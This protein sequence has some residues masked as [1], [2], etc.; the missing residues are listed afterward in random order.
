MA[1]TVFEP[2]I[3]IL[4]RLTALLKVFIV[5]EQYTPELE[6]DRRVPLHRGRLAGDVTLRR[7]IAF[8]RRSPVFTRALLSAVPSSFFFFYAGC[9]LYLSH[10]PLVDVTG[11]LPS[12]LLHL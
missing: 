4:E 9:L 3:E 11:I 8:F 5:L 10:T 7:G 1:G 12:L 2:C 6:S